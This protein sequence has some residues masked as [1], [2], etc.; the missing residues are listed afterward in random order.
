MSRNLPTQG[1]SNHVVQS[2]SSPL[3]RSHA[4]E[5]FVR[6]GAPPARRS[7][8][9]GLLWELP[10]LSTARQR[11]STAPHSWCRA[12]S[13]RDSSR[14][15]PSRSVRAEPQGPCSQTTPGVQE[16]V[17]IDDGWATPTGPPELG[18]DEAGRRALWAIADTS[19]REQVTLSSTVTAHKKRPRPRVWG[20]RPLWRT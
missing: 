3:H 9:P 20:A 17:G 6:R 7:E 19:L 18:V 8:G 1:I 15:L 14:S 13:G 2:P 16:D 5:R 11:T 10:R 12:G 4:S